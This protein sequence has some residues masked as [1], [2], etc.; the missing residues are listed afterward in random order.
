MQANINGTPIY[1]EQHGDGAPII[2][3]HGFPEDH[4][5]MTACF[6][7]VFYGVNG[8]RRLYIDLPGL[9]KSPANPLIE[10]A[11][12]MLNTLFQF[13]EQLLG[14]EHFFLMGQS[15]GGYLALGLAQQLPERIKG[16]YFLCPCVVAKRE[17]RTLPARAVMKREDVA[18][19]ADDD[20]M[21]FEEF[22]QTATVIT[23]ETWERYKTEILPGLKCAD[24]VFVERYQGAGYGFSFE[25]EL[26]NICF[27]KP[28]T[29][30]LGRQ[31]ECVGYQDAF[32]LLECF[33]CASFEIVDGAGHN[34][35]I[36]QPSVF[37]N[38]VL[39]WL[40]RFE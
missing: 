21:D 11:D 24:N 12:D 30:L 38:S 34:L 2:C 10:N 26:K 19:S 6:E 15:Y 17:R 1:Y 28:T 13:I 22:T 37:R 16:V 40:N 32:H 8:F 33:P 20:P 23:N 35:Q 5:A 4:R 9:G 25:S 18:L 7:P 31:D 14:S 39:G 36:E 29:F 27:A 3:I